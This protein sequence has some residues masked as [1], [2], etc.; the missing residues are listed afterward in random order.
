LSPGKK[1][2]YGKWGMSMAWIG[3]VDK[4]SLKIKVVASAGVGKEY[5]EGIDCH[6]K[7]GVVS[8]FS[9]MREL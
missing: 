5:L 7:S 6:K 2:E 9:F 1:R 3:L 4:A 8:P